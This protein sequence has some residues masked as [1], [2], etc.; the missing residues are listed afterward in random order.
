MLLS[1][2][3]PNCQTLLQASMMQDDTCIQIYSRFSRRN[4]A[5]GV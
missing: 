3:S 4:V 1:M 2:T 5:G